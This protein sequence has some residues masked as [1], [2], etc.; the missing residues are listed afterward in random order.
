MF[1]GMFKNKGVQ[2]NGEGNELKAIIEQNEKIKNI[3][4]RKR[5]FF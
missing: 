4:K 2:W 1:L 3:Q 5:Y